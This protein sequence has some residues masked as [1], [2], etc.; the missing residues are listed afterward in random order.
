MAK[1]LSWDLEGLT[2]HQ[3]RVGEQASAVQEV[4]KG[5]TGTGAGEREMYGMLVG[6]VA[7][8]ALSKFTDEATDSV[9]SLSS[10]VTT[11]HEGLGDTIANY[12]RADEEF[13]QQSSATTKGDEQ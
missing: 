11:R 7:F 10:M 6:P 13:S 12:Q 5:L 2:G 3:K 8:D 4:S 1:A 9:E